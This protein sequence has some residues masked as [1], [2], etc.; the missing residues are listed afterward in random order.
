M[1]TDEYLIFAQ[2]ARVEFALLDPATAHGVTFDRVEEG[3]F[4]DGEWIMDRVWNGDQTDYG[5]N[6]T[7]RPRALRVKVATY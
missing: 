7:D 6:F 5:L 3:R 2:N 4:E 1:G